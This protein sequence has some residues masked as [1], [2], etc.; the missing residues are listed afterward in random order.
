MPETT[1]YRCKRCGNGFI[2]D[3]LLAH[4]VQERREYHLPMA[5]IR[6]NVCESTDVEPVRS[7][8]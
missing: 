7:A 2:M 1:G 5:P 4:E 3:R 8:A 6:C